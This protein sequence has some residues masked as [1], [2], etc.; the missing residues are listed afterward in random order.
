MFD[1]VAT[2]AT[3]LAEAQTQSGHLNTA[4]DSMEAETAKMA[5]HCVKRLAVVAGEDGVTEGRPIQVD[6]CENSLQK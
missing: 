3:R 2:E 5:S 1:E 6:D 4:L